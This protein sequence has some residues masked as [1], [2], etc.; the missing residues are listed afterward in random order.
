MKRR[1]I[2]AL[3][4]LALVASPALAEMPLALDGSVVS[5]G[6]EAVR[7]PFGGVIEEVAARP[8]DLIGLGDPVASI[9]T[10]KVYA[11]QDGVVASVCA[12]PGDGAEGIIARYGA[13][14]YV[15]PTNRYVVEASTE[16]AYNSSATRYVHIGEKVY[17]SCTKDGSH[18]GTGI[19]TKVEAADE[20]GVT[21]YTLEVTGGEFYIGETVGAFRKSN[22]ASTSRIGRGTVGQAQAVAIPGEGSVLKI[23]V[24]PGDSVERGQLLF[25]T[26]SGA[27]DGLYAGDSTVVSNLRGIVAS[28]DTKTGETVAKD[29][30]LI[31]VY[32]FDKLQIEARVNVLDLY[33]VHEGDAVEIEFD[34]D[35]DSLRRYPG[36]VDSISYVASGEEGQ[37]YYS[38]YISF[39]ADEHVRLGMPA[40]VYLGEAE[41]PE[42]PDGTEEGEESPEDPDG[43]EEGEEAAH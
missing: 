30:S 42:D 33:A 2:G 19:V 35:P 24:Q 43:S 7:A 26:V 3:L 11:P 15:E 17:L 41:P 23:H 27:L 40:L 18:R 12:Q 37:T 10:T 20:G 34:L 29:A 38:A 36:T 25:E 14:M 4:A 1:L 5:S 13:V 39:T 16:K 22:Y 32:P 6:S 8:G 9:V 28:V 31:T 21:K